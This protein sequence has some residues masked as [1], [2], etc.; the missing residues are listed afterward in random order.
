M[1]VE[2][3]SWAPSIRY[4]TSTRLLSTIVRFALQATYEG[5]EGRTSESDDV[6]AVASHSEG[7]QFCALRLPF[8]RVGLGSLLFTFSCNDS[9]VLFDMRVGGASAVLGFNSLGLA[10]PHSMPLNGSL[11]VKPLC[12]I[13]ESMQC[14]QL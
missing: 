8:A 11:G 13:D 7:V 10:E 1:E 4:D 6:G 2:R 3:C 5:I 12:N 14:L 9:V